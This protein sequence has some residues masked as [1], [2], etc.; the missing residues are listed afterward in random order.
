MTMGTR[1]SFQSPDAPSAA[2]ARKLVALDDEVAAQLRALRP[3]QRLEGKFRKMVSVARQ[4]RDLLYRVSTDDDSLQRALSDVPAEFLALGDE[5]AQLAGELGL[6]DCASSDSVPAPSDVGS[7]AATVNGTRIN[8]FTLEAEL[9]TLAS[10][11]KWVKSLGSPSPVRSG[12]GFNASFTAS[13]LSREIVYVVVE[14]EL[15]HRKIAL[16]PGD[17]E[18]ARSSSVDKIGGAAIFDAFPKSYQD[19][20]VRR[21]AESAALSFALAGPGSPGEQSKAYYDAHRD[22]FVQACVSHILVPSR[23]QA[24]QIK[25]RLDGGEN[26]ADVARATS[27]DTGS[28]PR[29]GDLG[30]YGR[31]NQF[32][33]EFSQAIFS[34]PVGTVG[35]PV[36]TKYGYHLILVRS[37]DTPPYDKVAS[38]VRDEAV[39]ATKDKLAAW[40]VAVFDKA[41]ISVKTK[42]G[43]WEKAGAQSRVVPP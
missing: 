3:P 15:A 28:A 10:N 8:S 35:A 17:L 27:T 36:K 7:Y 1:S 33:P 12:G 26:F 37:R 20:A 4:S 42:Y 21:T 13:V 43:R 25:G 19:T 40:A 39:F 14:K 29:G 6:T 41:D 16:G 11:D 23:Q 22:T 31:Q 24:V 30:C 2:S 9:H 32:L 34:Q 5:H 38:Q 18:A